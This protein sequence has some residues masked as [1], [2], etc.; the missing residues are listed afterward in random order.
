LNSE[1][2]RIDQNSLGADITAVVTDLSLYY[3]RP[4]LIPCDYCNILWFPL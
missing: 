3:A 4:C 1:L 2:R